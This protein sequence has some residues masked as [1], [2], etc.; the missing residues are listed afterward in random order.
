MDVDGFVT[1]EECI[2]LVVFCG[3]LYLAM[4]QKSRPIDR[5]L[6]TRW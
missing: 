3:H 2:F 1:S 6:S 4:T 5:C